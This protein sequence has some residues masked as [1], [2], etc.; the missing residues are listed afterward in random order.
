[1]AFD[2]LRSGAGLYHQTGQVV[3]QTAARAGR[4]NRGQAI[5]AERHRWRAAGGHAERRPARLRGKPPKDLAA[6]RVLRCVAPSQAEKSRPDSNTRRSDALAAIFRCL[7]GRLGDV[8]KRRA[9]R[10]LGDRH[11]DAADPFGS[12]KAELCKIAAQGVAAQRLLLDRQPTRLGRN[13][14]ACRAALLLG[15]NRMPGRNMASAR[16]LARRS[17]YGP[18]SAITD[19]ADPANLRRTSRFRAKC[20]FSHGLCTISVRQ[21]SAFYGQDIGNH[22]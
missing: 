10:G 16:P 7:E 12:E 6:A 11:V 22:Q 9:R 4:S 13:N 18:F 2:A 1:M 17:R 20:A 3:H 15:A 8:W 19:S 14:A 5:A 21:H